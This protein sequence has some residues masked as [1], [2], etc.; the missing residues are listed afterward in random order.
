MGCQHYD[1]CSVLKSVYT[2]KAEKWTHRLLPTYDQCSAFFK[3]ILSKKEETQ[4]QQIFM[5]IRDVRL[6]KYTDQP[7]LKECFLQHLYTI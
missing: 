3:I 1:L 4:F 7:G 2:Q 5:E 6:N